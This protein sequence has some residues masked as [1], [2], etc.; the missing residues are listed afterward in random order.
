MRETGIV[1][2]RAA[3]QTKRKERNAKNTKWKEGQ[4]SILGRA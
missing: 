3:N 2:L 4:V 1:E